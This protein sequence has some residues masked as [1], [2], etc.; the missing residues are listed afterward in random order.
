M[1]TLRTRI[2]ESRNTYHDI[3]K[4]IRMDVERVSNLIFPLL[5]SLT[6]DTDKFWVGRINSSEG[7]F[8]IVRTNSSILPLRIFKGNF[9]SILIQG[10][11]YSHENNA[12]IEVKFRLFWSSKLFLL[13]ILLFPFLFFNFIHN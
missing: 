7:T 5:G 6:S 2:Y 9:F 4:M 13:S 10:Q 8:K 3:F 12:R 11:V 1:A